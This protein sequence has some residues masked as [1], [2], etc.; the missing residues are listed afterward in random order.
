MKEMG[1]NLVID[2]YNETVNFIMEDT[3][4][5]VFDEVYSDTKHDSFL[6]L[7]FILCD[8]VEK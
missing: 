4:Y 1:K 7:V 6:R 3:A 5:S 8:E 2:V